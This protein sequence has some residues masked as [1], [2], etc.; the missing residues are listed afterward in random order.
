MANELN[1]KIELV[2]L[3]EKDGGGYLA[4][5]PKLPGCM[6]DGETPEEALKNVQDAIKCWVETA[7]ELNRAI[8]EFDEYKDENDYSGKILLRMPKTMHKI[9]SE[10]AEK[11][12]ISLNNL[13]QNLLSF[14]IGYKKGEKN[15]NINYNVVVTSK[16][17]KKSKDKW[18]E[19]INSNIDI[20]EKLA[21]R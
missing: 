3:S 10:M 6:S 12:E 5:V 18:H 15:V 20:I 2:K 17:N 1:Y 21:M 14:A 7:K 4:Y 9:L 13:I 16:I 11:E 8:P 19:R